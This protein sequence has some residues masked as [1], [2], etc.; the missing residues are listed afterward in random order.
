VSLLLIALG[1]A[2]GT[3]MRYGVTIGLA[4]AVGTAFPFGTLLANALGSLLLGVVAELFSGATLAG[5][6]FRLILG[7]GVMGGFTTYSSF[8]LETLRMIEQGELLRAGGYVLATVLL[9]LMCGVAG[10]GIARGI[11]GGT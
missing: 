8:N 4:K 6:D 2:L 7:V 11:T 5:T 10:L 9:C 3:L 1:G